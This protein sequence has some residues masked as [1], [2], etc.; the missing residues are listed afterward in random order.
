MGKMAKNEE[1]PQFGQKV[2]FS[3]ARGR[4]FYIN[5]SRRG[6]VPGWE[7]FLYP[8][9]RGVWPGASWEAS[10]DLR[11]RGPGRQLPGAGL[12]TQGAT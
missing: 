3:G 10:G 8:P 4:G 7:G 6:P 1:N 12:E 2:G 11:D 9:G 5:P